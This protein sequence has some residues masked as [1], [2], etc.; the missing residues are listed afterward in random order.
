MSGFGVIGTQYQSGMYVIVTNGGTSQT[1]TASADSAPSSSS[2]G[3]GTSDTS[4]AINSATPSENFPIGSTVTLTAAYYTISGYEA[5]SGYGSTLPALPSYISSQPSP[6]A[7]WGALMFSSAATFNGLSNYFYPDTPLVE[8]F[9]GGTYSSPVGIPLLAGDQLYGGYTSGTPEPLFPDSGNLGAQSDYDASTS[10]AG[11]LGSSAAQGATTITTAASTPLPVVP[12]EW[13]NVTTTSNGVVRVQVSATITGSQSAGYTLTLNKPL[14]FAASSGAAIGYAGPASDVTI[15]Y[16]NISGTLPGTG[17]VID[18]SGLNSAQG[19]GWTIE[20]NNIH[21]EFAGGASYYSTNAQGIA[22]YGGDESTVEYNCLQRIGQQAINPF[23]TNVVFDYN[24]VENTPYN[25]DASGNGDTGCGKWW[26]TTNAQIVDNAFT[27]QETFPSYGTDSC[28]WLDGG[29][30]GTLISGNYFFNDP[31]RAIT[32]ET[33]YNLAVCN[34]LF[35]QVA[36]GVYLNHTGG[37]DIPGSNYNNEVLIGDPGASC[38]GNT[39][40]NALQAVDLWSASSRSCLNSGEAAGSESDSYCSGGFPVQPLPYAFFTHYT[41][42]TVTPSVEVLANQTC[43]SGSP[44]TSVT[45]TADNLNPPGI[46]AAPAVDDYVGVAAPATTTTSDTANVSTFTGSGTITGVTSTAGFP[47]AGQLLVDT[48][49]GQRYT[50]TGAVL[51]YTGTSGGNEFTGVN[52]VSGSGTLDSGIEQVQPSKV[53]G[54]SCPGG[55][56]QFNVTLTVSPGFT[57]NLTADEAMYNTGTCAY[58][59]TTAATPTSPM[60]PAYADSTD[61]SYYDGCAWQERNVTVEGNTMEVNATAFNAAAYPGYVGTTWGATS[62]ACTTGTSGNCA[63]V[64]V[65]YQFPGGDAAP[66]NNT[67]LS[68]ALMSNSTFSSPLNNLNGSTP[69]VGSNSGQ[70]PSGNGEAPYNT[71]FASNTYTGTW[72]FQAFAQATTC[73]ISWSSTFSWVGTGGGGGNA[74][75]LLPLTGSPS[76]ESTWGQD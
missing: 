21:D 75:G 2:T 59:D 44:C 22:I 53:T 25:P 55:N 49:A 56:C 63:E 9:L 41:D 48:S 33:G 12:W 38:A 23:G 5:L 65:G 3:Y 4:I 1:F 68:N 29:N 47:S 24:Q 60:A 73:T 26:Q 66:Y 18:M 39:F 31:S 52:L 72:S 17:N 71:L 42:G 10:G 37:W 58:Y 13:L 20:H 27:D 7:T 45:L 43:S 15:E 74:C 28:V 64:V 30:T 69:L 14:P 67:V 36:Q 40:D 62:N 54:V 51:S 34:N 32:D 16:M 76:W 70:A 57:S 11:T 35:D 46:E 6:T 50:A 19:S 61:Y 8:F